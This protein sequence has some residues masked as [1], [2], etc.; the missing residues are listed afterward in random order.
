MRNELLEIEEESR[1]AEDPLVPL[2]TAI[3]TAVDTSL[4]SET[5]MNLD[6]R[7]RKKAQSQLG[8]SFTD[9]KLGWSY[10]AGN[11]MCGILRQ[12]S[13]LKYDDAAKD[14]WFTCYVEAAQANNANTLSID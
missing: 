1:K 8:E 2:R 9:D 5:I 4:L 13:L 10:L 14:D 3:M 7:L 12:Y 11:F 6:D